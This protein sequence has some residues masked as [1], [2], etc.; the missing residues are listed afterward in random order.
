MV[1]PSAKKAGSAADGKPATAPGGVCAFYP[2]TCGGRI[3]FA[4]TFVDGLGPFVTQT[5]LVPERAASHGRGMERERDQTPLAEAGRE[6]LLREGRA[7]L[8]TLGGRR[9]AREFCRRAAAV[10]TRE[11]LAELLLEYILLHRSG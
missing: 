11:A 1:S 5:S 4:R 3:A 9:L 2:L 10:P 8:A 7:V 6:A